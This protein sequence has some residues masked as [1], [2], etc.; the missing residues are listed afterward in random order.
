MRHG[1]S[2]GA[3]GKSDLERYLG[4]GGEGDVVGF[5]WSEEGQ[6]LITSLVS[7]ARCSRGASST[8]ENA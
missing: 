5:A 1:P 8:G 4:A 6:V 7:H 2:H 3:W